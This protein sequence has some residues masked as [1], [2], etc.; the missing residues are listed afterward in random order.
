M[1][2]STITISRSVAA[3]PEQV[4]AAWTDASRLAEW[5]WPQLA[6]TTYAVDARPGG[7]Y[8]IVS[9][10]IGVTVSGVYADVSAPGR[11]EL[12][13]CWREDDEQNSDDPA[14]DTVVVT[15]EARDAGTSVTVAHT[16][17]AHAP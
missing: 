2:S 5:W 11:L 13:W 14:D 17:E 10:V 12:T 1:S 4:F 8:T 7:R 16:S 15:F 6:G 9:P 3:A